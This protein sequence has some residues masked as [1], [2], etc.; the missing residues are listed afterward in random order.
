[1]GLRGGMRGRGRGAAGSR[2]AGGVG[3]GYVPGYM[4]GAGYKKFAPDVS[5]SCTMHTLE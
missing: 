5:T 4:R 3:R 2:G 1:M